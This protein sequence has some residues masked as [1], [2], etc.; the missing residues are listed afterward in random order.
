M[1]AWGSVAAALAIA[2]TLGRFVPAGAIDWQPALAGQQPWRAWS[3]AGVHYSRLHLVANAAGLVGV[4]LLGTVGRLPPR[5]ALA[6]GLAWPLTHVGLLLQPE[7]TH[8]GGLSGVLHAGVAAAALHLVGAR[9]GRERLIGAALLAGLFTKV[10]AE[11]PWGVPLRY[12]AGW[13]IAV[14]PAIHASG[15]A[16]GIVC[17]AALECVAAQRRRF[18]PD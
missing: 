8:A 13:D 2:A 6:W 14:A 3:A 5:S 11:A 17:A 7:L 16:S 10:L 4:A 12:P 18:H 1:I 9:A 15:L